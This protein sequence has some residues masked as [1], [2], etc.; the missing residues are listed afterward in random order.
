MNFLL[1]AFLLLFQQGLPPLV[2]PLVPDTGGRV[3]GT[4]R[5]ADTGQPIAG[6]HVGL[7]ALGTSIQAA[8]GR[9]VT[10]D[11]NGRFTIKEL[12]PGAYTVIA[13][14]DGYFTVGSD[15]SAV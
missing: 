13:E 15:P 1:A 8:M 2:G 14:G 10:T 6:A 3:T 5:R 9:A 11:V 12:M 4:V 7:A